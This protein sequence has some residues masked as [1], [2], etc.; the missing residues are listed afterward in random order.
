MSEREY[1]YA[2]GRIRALET[3]LLN[4]IFFE[5]LL[6]TSSLAEAMQIMAETDYDVTVG[7]KDYERSIEDELLAAYHLVEKLAPEAKELEVFQFRWDLHNLKLLSM[8]DTQGRPSRLGRIPWEQL[9]EM[10][11]RDDGS[12][13]PE[14]IAEAMFRTTEDKKIPAL[15]QAY[16]RYGWRVLGQKD[17]LLQAYWTARLDLTNLRIFT[18]LRLAGG[19]VGDVDRLLVCPGIIP[20]TDWRELFELPWESVVAMLT[21]RGYSDIVNQGVSGLTNLPLLEQAVDDALMERMASARHM[22][23]GIEPVVAYLLAKEMEALNLR[24]V[25]AGKTNQMPAE[26]IRRRLRHGVL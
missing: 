22:A 2:V 26:T 5:R 1:A 16:Y 8:D 21:L 18:R 20:I 11:K 15:D 25:F 12:A 14:E 23:L 9:V 6:G 19:T 3:R 24:L 4:G 13:L 10:V 7:A 17:G